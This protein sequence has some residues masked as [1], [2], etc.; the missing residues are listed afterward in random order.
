MALVTAS[1][2]CAFR[3]AAAEDPPS[4]P[5]AERATRE[6][7][8]FSGGNAPLGRLPS[9]LDGFT[10]TVDAVAAESTSDGSPAA[11]PVNCLGV[12]GSP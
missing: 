11:E 7:G 3:A 4:L 9:R 8:R 10:F 6:T 12:S 5:A 1:A 2:L